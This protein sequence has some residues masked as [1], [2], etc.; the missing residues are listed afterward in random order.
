MERKQDCQEG[1]QNSNI[2]IN[3]DDNHHHHHH[4]DDDE[5]LSL[6][7]R[8]IACHSLYSLLVESHLNCLKLCLGEMETIE[9]IAMN[10]PMTA[11]P[12]QHAKLFTADRSELG[13]FMEAYCETLKKLKEEM[14]EP[15][16]ES[17]EFINLMYSQ[18]DELLLDIPSSR[19]SEIIKS[20][21]E[22]K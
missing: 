3:G 4:I 7:K 17:M 19:G 8:E 6:L 21:G 13:K 9:N 14:E 11:I 10:H 16:Q 22:C 1:L 20:D 18:L 12:N 2:T 5:D 15:Q